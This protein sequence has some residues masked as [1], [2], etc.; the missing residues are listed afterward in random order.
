MDGRPDQVS[1]GAGVGRKLSRERGE[2]NPNPAA[3][4][5]ELET[6]RLELARTRAQ[7][8]ETVDALQGRMNAQYVREQ[9]SSQAKDSAR[10]AG[11]NL[12]ETIK[13]NPVPAA[14]TGVGIV[15]LGWLIASGKDDSG[16]NQG[17]EVSR[18]GGSSYGS[19]RLEDGPHYY[20]RSSEYPTYY[21]G[22]TRRS[23]RSSDE[24]DDDSGRSRTQEAT[25]QARDR[26]SQMSGQL[27]DRAS[28]AG[29]QAQEQAQRAKNGFQRMLQ[30]NPL[31]V[32]ALA[33]GIG[34]AVG[35]AVPETEKENELMGEKRDEF[36]NQGQQKVR[37]YQDKAQR[38]AKE[39]RTAAE[40]E[41]DNQNLKG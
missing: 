1:P 35:F 3:T 41:A 27:Q 38:V 17:S 33:V 9:A 28:Q 7:M 36:A 39:A 20:D 12:G 13:Q 16:Q 29:G 37:D 11:S 2:V 8:S 40:K 18:Y 5:D 15:G 23:E 22:V 31:A 24:D 26:A 10:Q 21:E 32:G 19:S 25:G 4:D 34:A 6:L 14:L 30:E